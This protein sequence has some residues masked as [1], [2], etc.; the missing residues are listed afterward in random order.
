MKTAPV[1]FYLLTLLI[2]LKKKT[3][4][5]KTNFIGNYYRKNRI[6]H[7]WTPHNVGMNGYELHDGK[8]SV[9]SSFSRK[10]SWYFL[11]DIRQVH[12]PLIDY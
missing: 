7:C 1:E 12:L 2:A 5:K 11:N 6:K 10:C 4:S 9:A 8:A 3:Y